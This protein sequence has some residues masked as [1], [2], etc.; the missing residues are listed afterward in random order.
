MK[1]YRSAFTRPR[2]KADQMAERLDRGESLYAVRH[3]WPA[4]LPS[5]HGPEPG[6]VMTTRRGKPVTAEVRSL[7]VSPTVQVE[8]PL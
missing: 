4:I 5:Q 3:N 8:L 2:D 7:G 1:T 6:G